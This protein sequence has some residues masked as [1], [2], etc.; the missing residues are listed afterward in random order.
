MPQQHIHLK[1]EFF[2]MMHER[3]ENS[4]NSR[5]YKLAFDDISKT[6]QGTVL[7]VSLN[8]N[9]HDIEAMDN[10]TVDPWAEY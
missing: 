8:G 4:G 6:L 3:I 7:T 1:I 2:R 10:L 9:Q 5:L